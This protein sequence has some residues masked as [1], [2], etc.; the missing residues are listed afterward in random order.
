MGWNVEMS[1]LLVSSG[2]LDSSICIMGLSSA[3]NEK[4]A[5]PYIFAVSNWAGFKL[6]VLSFHLQAVS[7]FFFAWLSD[8]YHMRALFP[9]RTNAD[10]HNRIVLTAYTSIPGW[11]YTGESDDEFVLVSCICF[12][13]LYFT[14][15][16]FLANAGSA[17]CIPGILAYVRL[18][19]FPR[20]PASMLRSMVRH[21]TTSSHTLSGLLLR[22]SQSASAE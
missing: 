9:H 20:T 7:V 12:F 13:Y 3:R 15:G 4:S 19:S 2:W 14:T 18:Q 5:P 6:S 11:R 16:I 17:G 10:D 1:L 21:R 22:R 8:K